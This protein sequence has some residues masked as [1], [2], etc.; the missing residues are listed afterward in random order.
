MW[1]DEDDA[2][3][4]A[5]S[6]PQTAVPDHPSSSSKFVELNIHTDTDDGISLAASNPQTVAADDDT[7]KAAANSS[8]SKNMD[9]NTVVSEVTAAA[10]PSSKNTV[11][12]AVTA[13]LPTEVSSCTEEDDIAPHMSEAELALHC[14]DAKKSARKKTYEATGRKRRRGGQDKEYYAK[15]SQPFS[16]KHG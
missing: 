13:P 16:K 2:I 5:A 3:S 7:V 12:S 9:A 15:W 1:Q 10:N 14:A 4:F 11:V 6:N 8:S